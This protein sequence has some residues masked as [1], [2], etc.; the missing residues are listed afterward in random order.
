M[1]FD[2]AHYMLTEGRK[3]KENP[4]V[5]SSPSKEAYWKLMAET[6]NMNR[7]HILA[8]KKK[9]PT[10]VKLIPHEF[11]SPVHQSKPSKPKRHIPQTSEKTLDAP[12]LI[13][14]YYLNLLDWGSSNI[15][16]IALGS[17]VYLWDGLNG[18]ASELVTIDDENGPVTSVS[19]AADGQHI[20]IGL[21]SSDVQL[22]DSTANQLVCKFSLFLPLDRFFVDDF[23][24]Q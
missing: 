5:V 13:D 19:W 1:D 12:D 4:S 11:S 15:L 3:G 23:L 21:N 20:A 24:I 9:P 14:D 8:F 18:S 7:T 22:W 6:F 17:T 10:A 16:A 2:Y